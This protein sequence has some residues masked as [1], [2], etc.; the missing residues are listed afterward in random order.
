[1]GRGGDPAE[2]ADIYHASHGVSIIIIISDFGDRDVL[3][4]DGMLCASVLRMSE[5]FK[6]RRGWADATELHAQLS[7]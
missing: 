2:L 1:M 7:P 3:Q 6:A 5:I 4:V